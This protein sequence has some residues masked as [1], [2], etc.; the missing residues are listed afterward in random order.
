[1]GKSRETQIILK[2]DHRTVILEMLIGGK[3]QAKSG[4]WDQNRVFLGG[5]VLEVAL[6][7]A[8]RVLT[9]APAGPRPAPSPARHYFPTEE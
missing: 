3:F 4:G 7:N 1:M 6:R 2:T 5:D 9:H 8:R